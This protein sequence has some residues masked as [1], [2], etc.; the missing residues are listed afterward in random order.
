V[1]LPGSATAVPALEALNAWVR[2][3][4]RSPN[5]RLT[6]AQ[7]TAGGGNATGGL[8]PADVAAGRTLFVQAGCDTCHGGSKWTVST[9]DFV[10]PPPANQI[11]TETSPAPVTGNPVGAQYLDRFLRNIGSFNLGV[12]GQNNPIGSNVGA[13]EKA[14]GGQDGLGF[15][16]NNDGH[17]NGFNVPSLLAIFSVPP[18]YHNGS[19]ETL[20]CVLSNVRHRTANNT[21]TDVLTS[22][23]DQARV[24]AFLST[25]DD[26]TAP[27]VPIPACSPAARITT[28]VTRNG[29]GRLKVTITAVSSPGSASDPSAVNTVQ[30]I[31]WGVFTNGT[32]NVNGVGL[33]TTGQRTPFPT[34]TTSATFFVARVVATQA[35]TIRFTAADACGN[36]NSFVGG[37]PSAF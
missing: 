29:D 19:C 32:V 4:V 6:T 14:T 22:P 30:A 10:S 34:G 1:T 36:F 20:A 3:A 12:P 24:V 2:F 31:T 18:Y 9:K 33:V 23:A 28:Q 17:G 25:I 16:F 21:R 5:A 7:L 8:N 37:G 13:V 35:T 15:D 11:F 27:I 26:Q